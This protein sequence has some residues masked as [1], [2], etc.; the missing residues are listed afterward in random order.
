MADEVNSNF[1]G[2]EEDASTA[3]DAERH[4]KITVDDYLGDAATYGDTGLTSYLNLG[5]WS[6][7]AAPGTV[8]SSKLDTGAT[9]ADGDPDPE[10]SYTVDTASGDDMLAAFLY[11]RYL[12]DTRDRYDADA[13]EEANK[14]ATP[15]VDYTE[16]SQP[17]KVSDHYDSG[18]AD[19][20]DGDGF[21]PASSGDDHSYYSETARQRLTEYTPQTVGW[22]D[23]TEGHRITTTR[24]DKIE[25]IGG[26][27]KLIVLGRGSGTVHSDWSG[28][29]L[30]DTMEAPGNVTSVSWR[31]VPTGDD[32]EHGWLWVEEVV[33]GH[34]VER[35]HGTMRSEHYGDEIIAIVGRSDEDDTIATAS[36]SDEM[37]AFHPLGDTSLGTGRFDEADNQWD[38]T[39]GAPPE[40]SRPKVTSKVHAQS[41]YERE[42]YDEFTMTIENASSIEDYVGCK[43]TFDSDGNVST[44]KM[45]NSGLVDIASLFS[46]VDPNAGAFEEVSFPSDTWTNKPSVDRDVTYA[47]NIKTVVRANHIMEEVRCDYYLHHN[48]GVYAP[49]NEG[50]DVE[51]FF[52]AAGGAMGLT[53]TYE[54]W[55][56]VFT[57]LFLGTM[58]QLFVAAYTTVGVAARLEVCGAFEFQ[59][60]L[61][62]CVEVKLLG[63]EINA[64]KAQFDMNRVEA[65]LLRMKTKLTA[66]KAELTAARLGLVQWQSGGMQVH[67]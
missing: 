22:R 28:G 18:D 8:A 6:P 11:N 17:P 60:N 23:H 54:L 9:D 31:E 51:Q 10:G 63:L 2:I 44:S 53:T 41:V 15:A 42:Q 13:A 62:A 7:S 59:G 35:F 33:K 5:A 43:P 58:T 64:G 48:S 45:S 27:Y 36:S 26:N 66:A 12:D 4:L 25:V 40:R 47:E 19:L 34:V 20:T 55:N 32:D 67:A 16:F 24:G 30:V 39:G 38:A 61:F 52:E 1:V 65:R 14:R 49:D 29:M 56:G 21:Y 3:S 50:G 57:E 37:G 46:T